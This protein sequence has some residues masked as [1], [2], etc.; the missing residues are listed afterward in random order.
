MSKKR[1]RFFTKVGSA[2]LSTISIAFSDPFFHHKVLYG[3]IG[4]RIE[5]YHPFG[6]INP[7]IGQGVPKI[8]MRKF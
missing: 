1:F 8:T 6:L 4:V 3:Q 2:L 5:L 7:R